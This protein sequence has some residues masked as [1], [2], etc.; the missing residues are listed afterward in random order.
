MSSNFHYNLYKK[1]LVQAIIPPSSVPRNLCHQ[2]SEKIRTTTYYV[3]SITKMTQDIP[4]TK[5]FYTY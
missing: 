1:K 2:I 5:A 4:E 3:P